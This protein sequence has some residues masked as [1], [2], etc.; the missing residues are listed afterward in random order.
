M[1]YRKRKRNSLE[2]ILIIIP[3]TLFISS[4]IMFLTS[5][6]Y[7]VPESPS[8]FERETFNT[9]IFSV[10][11]IIVIF[12]LGIFGYMATKYIYAKKEIDSRY[13]KREIIIINTKK[14]K[15]CPQCETVITSENF[16]PCCGNSIN[17]SELKNGCLYKS[18]CK[19][20]DHLKSGERISYYCIDGYDDKYIG[21]CPRNYDCETCTSWKYGKNEYKY[22]DLGFELK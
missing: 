2:S 18:S 9:I 20:C 13:N 5:S 17:P 15:L 8:S 11:I 3:I 10:I 14:I 21:I 16:C 4:I 1:K 22:C 7:P 12:I 6:S 19:Y